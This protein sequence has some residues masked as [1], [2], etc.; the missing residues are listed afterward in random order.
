MSLFSLGAV[1]LGSN[2]LPSPPAPPHLPGDSSPPTC[3]PSPLIPS[4]AATSPSSPP[5]PIARNTLLCGS[6]WVEQG[7][8]LEP[9]YPAVR[10]DWWRCFT[11]FLQGG[12]FGCY[13]AGGISGDPFP[14]PLCSTRRST[15]PDC[16]APACPPPFSALSGG[17]VR[18]LANCAALT[19]AQCAPSPGSPPSSSGAC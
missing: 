1:S 9:Q 7:P 11:S 19:Y 14:G 2:M 10:K 13:Q 6:I 15:S 12:S 5:L 3:L 18:R 8:V 4:P 16:A 17:D